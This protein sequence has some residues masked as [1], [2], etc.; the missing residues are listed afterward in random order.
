MRSLSSLKLDL[1]LIGNRGFHGFSIN[2][3]SCC[4][5]YRALSDE[6]YVV[7]PI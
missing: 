7:L 6:K 1:S 4:R 3:L 5:S 2:S